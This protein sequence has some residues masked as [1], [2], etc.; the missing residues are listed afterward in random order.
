MGKV[1]EAVEMMIDLQSLGRE[2]EASA[3][4]PPARDAER[5]VLHCRPGIEAAPLQIYCSAL[6]FAP[7]QS[8]V[9]KLFAEYYLPPWISRLPEVEE[10][11][12]YSL[13]TL[14][15]Q[16]SDKRARDVAFSSDDSRLLF[17]FLDPGPSFSSP[18][19][20]IWDAGT[21]VLRDTLPHGG[22]S[23]AGYSLQN[24]IFFYE[25]VDQTVIVQDL[26]GGIYHT[27]AGAGSDLRALCISPNGQLLATVHHV[28][29]DGY[30]SE[31]TIMSNTDNNVCTV[32]SWDLPTGLP[33][34]ALKGELIGYPNIDFSPDGRFVALISNRGGVKLCGRMESWGMDLGRM[35]PGQA[36]ASSPNGE[37]SA[38]ISTSRVELWDPQTG[39]RDDRFPPDAQTYA[40]SP[41]GRF[42]ALI[43]TG[44]AELW[45]KRASSVARYEAV[46]NYEAQI[47]S[48]GQWLV[49]LPD[50]GGDGKIALEVIQLCVRPSRMP[51]TIQVSF[52]WPS[53]RMRD[54]WP[55][56]G[57]GCFG[58]GT[59]L[60]LLLLLLMVMVTVTVAMITIPAMGL[61]MTQS[62]LRTVIF[63]RCHRTKRSD[64]GPC[65]SWLRLCHL[66]LTVNVS[67]IPTLSSPLTAASWPSISNTE[68][69]ESGM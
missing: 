69:S 64:F 28:R 22:K 41:D 57:A 14:V 44:R 34:G 65:T 45:N 17:S 37:F 36:Y 3:L 66:S 30:D 23:M 63:S 27:V 68:L 32:K 35:D 12:D 15:G 46:V 52:V 8:E 11:W 13:Q 58:C 29:G 38:E 33:R 9:R 31:S 67:F 53:R 47:P 2:S 61:K 51:T 19:V 26:Q 50:L 48:D 7:R 43:S 55:L 16:S 18:G 62:C 42:V 21:G 59:L 54:Y 39:L 25:I 20:E 4:G 60:V 10:Y 5:F 56:R 1:G 49:D 40:F 6:V 24:G